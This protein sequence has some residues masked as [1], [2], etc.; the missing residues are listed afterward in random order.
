MAVALTQGLTRSIRLGKSVASGHDGFCTG[1]IGE[2]RNERS[3][4]IDAGEPDR[5][6]AALHD[7]FSATCPSYDRDN[8]Y[9]D[10]HGERNLGPDAGIP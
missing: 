9:G 1:M 6:D 3:N 7:R 5:H 8:I 10:S 4:E 2:G